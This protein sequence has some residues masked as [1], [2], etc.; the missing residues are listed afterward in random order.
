MTNGVFNIAKGRVIEFYNRVKSNDPAGS[1]F[2]VVLLKANE[3]EAALRDHDNLSLLLA[4]AGNTEADFTGAAYARKVLTDAE[5]AA[6]PAPDDANERFEVTIPNQTWLAAGGTVTNALTKML[7]CYDPDTAAGDDTTII[8]L[9]DHDFS[10]TTDGN[11][12]TAQINA[13]GFF[14]AA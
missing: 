6:L 3:A 9:T 13:A 5:L 14:Q 10:V 7:I 8:P 1:A 12:L 2:I 4:A 11:D